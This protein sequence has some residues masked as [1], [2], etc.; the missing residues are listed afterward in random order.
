MTFAFPG[1]FDIPYKTD[2][3]RRFVIREIRFRTQL[4]GRRKDKA[5]IAYDI[6]KALRRWQEAIRRNAPLLSGFFAEA[7]EWREKCYVVRESVGKSPQEQPMTDRNR[8]KP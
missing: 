2:V 4:K 5:A 8:P 7:P 1:V 6:K 3:H